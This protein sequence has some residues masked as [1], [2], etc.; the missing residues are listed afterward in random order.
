LEDIFEKV[1]Y[2]GNGKY[3]S[4]CKVLEKTVDCFEFDCEKNTDGFNVII[5]L[6]SDNTPTGY[7]EFLNTQ[8][9]ISKYVWIYLKFK[10]D[11]NQITIELNNSLYKVRDRLSEN[12]VGPE[13]WKFSSSQSIVEESNKVPR[14]QKYTSHL[15]AFLGNHNRSGVYMSDKTLLPSDYMVTLDFVKDIDIFD[16][17]EYSNFQISYYKDDIVLYSW[18]YSNSTYYYR[19]TSL[20]N[21]KVYKHTRQEGGEWI[22]AVGRYD[23]R[24]I[25][26]DL[27]YCS[28]KYLVF[29]IIYRT[30]SI[31]ALFDTTIDTWLRLEN[32]NLIVD[33][34]DRT[35]KIIELPKATSI[36]SYG[37]AIEYM[38]GLE[39]TY[40]DLRQFIDTE[41]SLDVFKKFG[42]WY[43]IRQGSLIIA[44]CMSYLVYMTESEARNCIVLNNNTILIPSDNYYTIYHGVQR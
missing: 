23:E 37:S 16:G 26:K 27:L 21:Q 12:L 18:V 2:L 42:D 38:P 17:E 13:L 29:R 15:S 6:S 7:T 44:S 9:K 39:N 4:N 43:F 28:G 35:S 20:L 1:L 19:I 8:G 24:E 25:S 11:I 30:Y 40:L 36:Q 22:D 10:I 41:K 14:D 33:P 32:P 3:N 5:Y 34:L 31:V